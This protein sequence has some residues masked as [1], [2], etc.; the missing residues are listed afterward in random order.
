M[1]KQTKQMNKII[2]ITILIST[3][4][5]F[6]FF[7]KSEKK[8]P[9]LNSSILGMILLDEPNSL[10]IDGLISDLE[11]RWNLKI[12]SKEIG[13]EASVLNING[14]SVALGNI[15]APIPGDEVKTT[16]E[17]N[18]LWKNG[19]DEATKHKGHIILSI[20]NAG[21]N[22]IKEN[23]LFNQIADSVLRNS[24]SIGIYI[25]GR[26]L[27]LKKEFY[28]FNS[29]SMSEE[30]LPLYNWI[31]FG[32]RQENGNQS[33]Y[34]YGLT[35]FGKKEMEIVKSNKNLEELSEMMFNL[36]HYVIAY[37]VTLKDGETIGMSAEQKLKISESKG[38]FIEGT[39]LK[40][41]Y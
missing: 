26:T 18:Y 8:N 11:E 19:I 14:Y 4:G 15:P 39:T 13:E 21:K 12:N 25:G 28:L 29:E 27:L 35:D 30:D 40:I 6:S 22:P 10:N 2:T 16:A 1:R 38:E 36:S 3:M 9:E 34:T 7:K 23:I 20:M 24:K 32:L 17:Y 5:L 31:Y 33:V 37:D 41:E